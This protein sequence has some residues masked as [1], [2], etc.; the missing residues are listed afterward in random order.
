MPASDRQDATRLVVVVLPCV[1]AMAMPWRRRISSASIVA[2]GTTGMRVARRQHFRVVLLH[3]G[4]CHHRIRPADIF[5]GMACHHPGAHRT[6][7]PGRGI[8]G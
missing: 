7:T 6:Q 4:G 2:R 1:P 5:G 8:L 3:R